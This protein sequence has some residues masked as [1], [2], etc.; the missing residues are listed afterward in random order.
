MPSQKDVTELIAH[1]RAAGFRCAKSGNQKHY[2]VMTRTGAAVI[3]A[4]GPIIISST[5]SEERFKEMT[6][7]R[8]MR[9]GVLKVDP[10]K[11]TRGSKGERAEQNGDEQ[12]K[13][14]PFSRQQSDPDFKKRLHEA[15]VA[16]IK[17]KS[18]AA[19]EATAEIRAHLEPVIA[20]LGGWSA[21]GVSSSSG[22][23]INEV[24]LTLHCWATTRGR[25]EMPK[26]TFR[27]PHAPIT[28]DSDALRSAV[29]NM[30][31][32]GHT[33]G[34]VWRPIFKVFVDELWQHAGRDPEKAAAR[35]RELLREAKGIVAEPTSPPAGGPP[36]Q[37]LSRETQKEPEPELGQAPR[38]GPL[39]S[40][41]PSL[42]LEAM[43]W[44]GKGGADESDAMTLGQKIAQLEMREEG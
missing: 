21:T 29:M 14:T 33:L 30:K 12:K 19:K 7:K 16:A 35:Y 2:K 39:H 22:V 28:A 11:A 37:P 36:L 5:P 34:D 13:K 8:L 43:F 41:V 17:K 9:A 4:D 38:L 25:V 31:N 23:K 40:V 3:D 18:A 44:A 1:I 10:Y 32:P 20:K 24:A 15:K 6:V 42:A 26:T 27:T